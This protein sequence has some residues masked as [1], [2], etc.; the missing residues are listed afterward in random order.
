MER[1]FNKPPEDPRE[2]IADLER[3]INKTQETI[4]EY[5]DKEW[6]ASEF[7]IHLKSYK[8]LLE[9]VKKKLHKPAA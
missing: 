9:E 5:K 1:K 2:E 4:K 8:K 6:D 7:E 3:A